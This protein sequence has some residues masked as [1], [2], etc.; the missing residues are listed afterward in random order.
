V[1]RPRRSE[2]GRKVVSISLPDEIFQMIRDLPNRSDYIA[3]LITFD[4]AMN[5]AGNIDKKLVELNDTLF[6]ME[7]DRLSLIQEKNRVE[8][9]KNI[10]QRQHNAVVNERLKLL[11]MFRAAKATPSEIQGWLSSR[12]DKLRD[13]GFDAVEDGTNWMKEHME[14]Q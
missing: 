5:E 12:L 4:L 9:Q 1:S 3:N 2:G 6:S 11:E 8:A 10:L 7:K 13:C 14:G